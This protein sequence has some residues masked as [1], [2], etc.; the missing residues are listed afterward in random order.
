MTDTAFRLTRRH[1]LQTAAGGLCA[2]A[3][4]R[5]ADAQTRVTVDQAN[6]QPRPIAIP[7]FIS[8]NPQLGRDVAIVVAADLESSGLFKLLNPAAFPERFNNSNQQPRTRDWAAAGAEALVVGQVN[9]APDGR[10][11][12]EYRLWDVVLSRL[13]IRSGAGWH[14]S[15]PTR[16]TRS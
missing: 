12:V 8:S 2:L 11:Q 14:T 10:V 6:I 13:P 3:L 16:S 5:A 7:D 9:Q 15:P 1:V 4:P